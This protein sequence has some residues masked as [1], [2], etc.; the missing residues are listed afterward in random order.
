MENQIQNNQIIDKWGKDDTKD[1]KKKESIY[2]KLKHGL[3]NDV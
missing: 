3:L 1:D 2:Y